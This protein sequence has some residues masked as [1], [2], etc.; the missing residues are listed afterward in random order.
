MVEHILDRTSLRSNL[1]DLRDSI[2][3]VVDVPPDDLTAVVAYKRAHQSA[4][5]L[6]LRHFVEEPAEE[7]LVVVGIAAEGLRHQGN[8]LE[9]CSRR[10]QLV[11]RVRRRWAHPVR[12]G[13]GSQ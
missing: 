9:E 3:Q 2:V 5:G 11:A 13:P 12:D 7:W 6:D 10:E 8:V 1:H 4:P